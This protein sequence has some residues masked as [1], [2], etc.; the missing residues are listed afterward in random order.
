MPKDF[1]CLE[2]R[3]A[4]TLQ[5]AVARHAKIDWENTFAQEPVGQVARNVCLSFPRLE[6]P[7]RRLDRQ[8]EGST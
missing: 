3:L 6:V 7:A 8:R 5:A 1:R 4:I 2:R